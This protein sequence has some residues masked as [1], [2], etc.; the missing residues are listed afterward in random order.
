MPYRKRTV[1]WCN[2]DLNLNLCLGRGK[3]LGMDGNRHIGS[4][5]NGSKKYKRVTN[6]YEKSKIPDL[7]IDDI[8]N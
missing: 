8:L 6:A 1:L 3:C 2:V 4:V 7:L 5:G